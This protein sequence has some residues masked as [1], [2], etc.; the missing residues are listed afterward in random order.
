MKGENV[1]CYLRGFVR[2]I[3]NRRFSYSVSLSDLFSF[4]QIKIKPIFLL[5]TKNNRQK[6]GKRDIF[7]LTK[8][9]AFIKLL[10]LFL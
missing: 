5:Q 4:Y 1:Y 7:G 8:K 6:V 9:S 3:K 2:K 10:Y